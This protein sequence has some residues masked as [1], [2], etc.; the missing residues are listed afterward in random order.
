[1][2]VDTK[3]DT[4]TWYEVKVQYHDPVRGEVR[5]P[6]IDDFGRV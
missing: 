6:Y 4:L 3:L 1:M 5:G 2:R